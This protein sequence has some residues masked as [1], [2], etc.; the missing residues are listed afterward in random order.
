MPGS[1]RDVACSKSH[2]TIWGKTVKKLDDIPSADSMRRTL[3]V[4]RATDLQSPA[5]RACAGQQTGPFIWTAPAERIL[6]KVMKC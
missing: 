5:R 3:V 1:C 4:M 6:E 2:G